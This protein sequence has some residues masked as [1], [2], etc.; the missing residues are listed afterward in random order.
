MPWQSHRVSL[1]TCPRSW[2]RGVFLWMSRLEAVAPIRNVVAQLH[3]ARLLEVGKGVEQDPVAAYGWYH[4]AAEAGSGTAR[5]AREALAGRMDEAQ[6]DEALR[7]AGA[8]SPG[9]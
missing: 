9:S 1:R 2:L 3:L 4:R 6:L 8:A 5:A 7:A